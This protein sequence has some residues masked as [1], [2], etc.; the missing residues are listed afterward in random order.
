MAQINYMIGDALIPV[1]DDKIPL[2]CHICNDIGKWG[3]GFTGAISK[4]WKEPEKR[5]RQW[6]ARKDNTFE[7]G[8]IQYVLVDENMNYY[9]SNRKWIINMVAQ[10]KIFK[11]EFG[12]PPIR[13]DALKQCF[14]NHCHRHHRCTTTA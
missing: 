10:H 12:G 9:S 2:I 3:A 6:F 8:M 13:Y 5:Y 7:L 1:N 14:E 4:K 11:D